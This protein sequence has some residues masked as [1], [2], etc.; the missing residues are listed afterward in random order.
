VQTAWKFGLVAL[1]ALVLV[2]LP[3][4]GNLLDVL[5]TALT[6]AFFAAIA[7]LVARMYR[8]YRLDIETL[9]SN[10]RLALYGSLAIAVLT[11]TAT[12]RL[13]NSGGAGVVRPLLGLGALPPLRVVVSAVWPSRNARALSR[14]APCGTVGTCPCFAA[15][16]ARRRSRPL[17]W[18]RSCFWRRRSPGSS[19]SRATPCGCARTRH[20]WPPGRTS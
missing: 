9:D 14:S 1:V 10:I 12:D 13:F 8:Q 4:G 18:C 15:N 6:I 3:G 20:G 5:L 7:I 19:F 2:V 11:F 16:Q 17:R